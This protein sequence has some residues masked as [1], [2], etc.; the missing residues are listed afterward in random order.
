MHPGAEHRRH[1]TRPPAQQL[2]PAPLGV[3]SPWVPS[4]CCLLAGGL[5]PAARGL[6]AGQCLTPA[7]GPGHGGLP[8]GARSLF[9][10]LS[11]LQ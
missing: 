10:E 2:C 5:C 6:W 3:Q 1:P 9:P 7:R 11:L 8:Q 4:P